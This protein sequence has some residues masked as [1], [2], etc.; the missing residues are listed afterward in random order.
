MTSENNKSIYR[1]LKAG[2]LVVNSLVNFEILEKQ[3]RLSTST[4][5]KSLKSKIKK[6]YPLSEHFCR[7]FRFLNRQ[8]TST[9]NSQRLDN[10][11]WS[12]FLLL[13]S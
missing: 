9:K 4:I 8:K 5:G 7:K 3:N 10:I 2:D 11:F 13:I 12:K 6:D 1:L